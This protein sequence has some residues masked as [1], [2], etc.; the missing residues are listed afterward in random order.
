V[1]CVYL[2]IAI[3]AIK[4]CYGNKTLRKVFNMEKNFV[5]KNLQFLRKVSKTSQE[6]LGALL[7]KKR[8][9]ISAYELNKI[10]PTISDVVALA[11]YFKVPVEDFII[12]DLEEESLGSPE[13][14][15]VLIENLNRK[16]NNTEV[17]ET[18]LDV[19]RLLEDLSIKIAETSEKIRGSARALDE[20]NKS[21]PS[22]DKD[23]F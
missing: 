18:L 16:A 11:Y 8:A 6:D 10:Q 19:S 17:I 15:R 23:A 7:G 5:G 13:Y 22:S 1:S 9:T 20:K 14:L 2:C 3:L 4:H 21:E 12:I